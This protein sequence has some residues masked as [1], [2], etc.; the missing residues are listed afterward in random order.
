MGKWQK[1][2][3]SLFKFVKVCIFSPHSF[4]AFHPLIDDVAK[5]IPYTCEKGH[6]VGG[7]LEKMRVEKHKNI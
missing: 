2:C 1:Y 5:V 3:S 7:E 6:G 4:L